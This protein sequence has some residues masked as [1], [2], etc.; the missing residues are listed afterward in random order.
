MLEHDRTPVMLGLGPSIHDFFK[1]REVVDGRAKP[2]HDDGGSGAAHRF[3]SHV[4]M[5]LP[6][7]SLPSLS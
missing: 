3:T 4:V 6:D 1:S 5:G 2:G 7:A